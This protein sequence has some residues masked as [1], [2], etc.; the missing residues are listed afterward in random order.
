MLIRKVGL[1]FMGMVF[2]SGN[3][4][5]AVSARVSFMNFVSTELRRGV[6]NFRVKLSEETSNNSSSK[7]YHELACD[8]EKTYKD[9]FEGREVSV[10][11]SRTFSMTFRSAINSVGQAYLSEARLRKDLNAY[12]K[13]I[14][15]F[16]SSPGSF[17][18]A[19]SEGTDLCNINFIEI[20][21]HERD[22]LRERQRRIE[23]LRKRDFS[24]LFSSGK[25]SS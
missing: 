20:A 12:D 21:E 13:A 1:F 10:P 17:S 6:D 24:E 25:S 23:E 5:L 22:S 7:D 14:A 11:L 19:V 15:W 4:L 8:F 18:S 3:E 2:L 9:C 16:K